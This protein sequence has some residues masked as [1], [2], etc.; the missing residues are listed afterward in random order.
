MINVNIFIRKKTSSYHHSVER[1]AENLKIT[2]INKNLKINILVCPVASKGFL[3]RIF[4]IFWS[5]FN[6][7]DVNHILGD[8]N[9]ISILMDKKKTINTFLDFRLFDQF[10]G[11]KLYIYKLL[12]FKIPIEKSKKI[13]FISN[14]TKR[15]IEKKLKKKINNSE[16]V[17]VPLVDNFTFKI[18]SNKKKNLLIIGTSENKNIKNM[19]LAVKGLNI[20][21]TI[22][23]KLKK[24]IINFCNNNK[25]NYKNLID[26]SNVKMKKILSDNDILLMVSKYEGFGMPIIE[27]QA[28]GTAVITSDIEPMKTVIGK[29]GL[30]VNPNKPKE[31]KKKIRKLINDKDYFLKI[32]KY[33]KLNSNNYSPE[34]INKKYYK[35]YSNILKK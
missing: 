23:G 15:D 5:Y 32:V 27:A 21:L 22:I 6:Q 10:E 8:I 25:I 17:S 26:I 16:V 14:F 31:I 11:L 24:D 18:N 33:G 13:T 2:N 7:G 19:I 3:R 30:I 28:S 4:L 9:F 29:N 34:I 12:W 1:I 35:I 20:N